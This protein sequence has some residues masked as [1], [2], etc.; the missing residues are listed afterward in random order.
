[1][2]KFTFSLICIVCISVTN[3]YAKTWRVNNN[4]NVTA[5]FTTLAAAHTGAS[6]G[7]TLHLEG[8]PTSYGSLTCSKK[9]VIIGP[10]FFLAQNPNTQALK[11]TARVD[12]ITFAA[13]SAGSEIMGLDFNSSS[14]NIYSNDIVIKRNKFSSTNGTTYDW[15]A[16]SVNI[17][18]INNNS[19]TPANNI[20]I[21]QNYGVRVDAGYASSGIL[22]SNNYILYGIAYGEGSTSTC[23]NL[24]ANAIALVQNNIFRNGKIIGYNSNF[25]NNIMVAGFFEGTGNLVSNNISNGT[26]FGTDNNNKANVDMSTVFVG[27]GDGISPDGQWKLKVG[28]PA[29]AAGYGSTA[30]N[31]IDAGMYSG[32]STYVLAGLPPIPAI[33]FFENQPIGSNS[34]PID[35]TVKVKSGN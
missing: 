8:S 13:G 10:G 18:Y 34:D 33:Y 9:L 7:D 30:Q 14:V 26:Q 15:A 25:T 23:L 27:A 35:V 29:I 3:S 4:N 17:Y 31:P 12:A 16:G 5:D 6:S 20:I 19:G 21:S 22:I 32:Q 11:Q 2:Y 1:M 24:Q 28:S